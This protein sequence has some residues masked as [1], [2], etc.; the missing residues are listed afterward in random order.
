L[1]GT[2]KAVKELGL[3]T[4]QRHLQRAAALIQDRL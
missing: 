1:V 4:L 3:P 2:T